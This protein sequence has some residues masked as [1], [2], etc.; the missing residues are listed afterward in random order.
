[1]LVQ[2]FPADSMVI[3]LL[4]RVGRGIPRWMPYGFPP[5]EEWSPRVNGLANV[6]PTYKLCMG[7]VVELMPTAAAPRKSLTEYREKIKRM[8]DHGLPVPGSTPTGNT[9]VGWRS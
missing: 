4:T 1:M 7:D 9:A 5:K 6:D 8:Y 3:D 2:E